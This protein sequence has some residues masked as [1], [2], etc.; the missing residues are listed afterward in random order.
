MRRVL[1][2][3]ILLLSAL[4]GLFA[5]DPINAVSVT[6]ATIVKEPAPVTPSISVTFNPTGL[7]SFT[8]TSS[9]EGVYVFV[10]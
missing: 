6:V 1:V 4:L 10:F 2:V 5:A 8:A 3:S 7:T 9:L